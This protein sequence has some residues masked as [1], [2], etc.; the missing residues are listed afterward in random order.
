MKKY[1][2]NKKSAAVCA[3]CTLSFLGM[4]LLADGSSHWRDTDAFILSSLNIK[5]PY[6]GTFELTI[7]FLSF[8]IALCCLG[9]NVK[10]PEEKED[11]TQISIADAYLSM[12]SGR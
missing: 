9:N 5:I 12:E 2:N 11:T 1:E 8:F 3:V 4:A 6:S 7:G 10:Q